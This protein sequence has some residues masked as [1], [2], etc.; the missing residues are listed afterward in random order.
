MRL[1]PVS[2][3]C[4]R[5]NGVCGRVSVFPPEVRAGVARLLKFVKCNSC[6]LDPVPA[7]GLDEGL[8][9]LALVVVDGFV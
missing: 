5:G 7:G 9:V 8:G 1:R 2:G 6:S 3:F 4:V